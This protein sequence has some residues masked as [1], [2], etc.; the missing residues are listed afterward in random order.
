MFPLFLLFVVLF[1]VVACIQIALLLFT[2]ATIKFS[3][4]KI[5]IRE[6]FPGAKA[7]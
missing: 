7:K 5:I 1:V 3:D 4:R 6:S 2:W